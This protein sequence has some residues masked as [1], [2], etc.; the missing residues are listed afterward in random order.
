MVEQ[1]TPMESGWSGPGMMEP[2]FPS[3]TPMAPEPMTF[4][5]RPVET[6]APPGKSRKKATKKKAAKGKKTTK[7]TKA[8]KSTKKKGKKGKKAKK[9]K[10][11]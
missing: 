9:G 3:A 8:K 10:R 4:D 11:R 5:P 1:S 6:A 7:K 2:L